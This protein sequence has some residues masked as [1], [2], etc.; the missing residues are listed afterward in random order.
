MQP[1]RTM[2]GTRRASERSFT[3]I[4]FR[5]P[6]DDTVTMVTETTYPETRNAITMATIAIATRINHGK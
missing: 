2:H 4:V 6:P 1:H 5:R 3:L